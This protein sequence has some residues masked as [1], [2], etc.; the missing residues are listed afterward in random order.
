MIVRA[1]AGRAVV[2]AAS[3]HRRPIKGVNRR[4]ILGGDCD[5]DRLIEAALAADPEI[6]FTV[7]AEARSRA[8][9][10]GLGDLHDQDVTEWSQRVLVERFGTGVVGNRKSRVIK[11]WWPF[12]V[13]R[14]STV[15]LRF[16]PRLGLSPVS[17]A[18][19]NSN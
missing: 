16:S 8:V 9:I 19:M 11:H 3:G 2:L 7:H 12:Q 10:L 4:S 5:M 18:L 17:R 1:Q 13:Q 15:V 14:R 6:R